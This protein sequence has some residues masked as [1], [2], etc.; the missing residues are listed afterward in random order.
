MEVMAH[1]QTE[2]DPLARW[3]AGAGLSTLDV[4]TREA[5][6]VIGVVDRDLTLR[7]INWT[8]AGLTREGVTG[9]SILDLFPPDSVE[10]A[11]DAYLNVLRTGSTKRFETIYRDGNNVL[12][13]DVH[14]GPIRFEGAVIG[15]IVITSNVTEQRRAHADRDRFFSLSL[16]MLVVVRPNGQLRRVNPALG[17]TLGYDVADL[18]G[19]PFI[20][21]VHP[22]DG[23]RTLEAYDRILRG[24]P[25]T[26]FENR[27]RR[28]DGEY[29]V[30]SWRA[31]VDPI[32]GDVYGVA[33]D[34]TEHRAT[35]AQLRHAMKMDAVGQL[36]GGIAHDFNNLLT[37][38]LG[39]S[40]LAL[41]R[42]PPDSRV[43]RDIEEIQNAGERA[44]TLT[45]QLLAFSRRQ[46]FTPRPL[47]LNAVVQNIEGLL[48][49]LIAEDVE[50][51]TL[52]APNLH[53]VR[54]DQGQVEQILMNLAVNARDAMPRG[55]TLTIETKNREL[56]ERYACE[57]VTV[58]A[59]SYVLLEVSD[60]GEGM[61]EET[62]SRMFEPFFTTKEQGKGTG[63]GLSMVYG[64]VQQ[65]GGHIEVQSEL[66]RGSSFQIY[67]PTVAEPADPL[68]K[69]KTDRPIARGTET[70]LLV[71]DEDLVRNFTRELL[72]AL[73]YRV[74]F[75][76]DGF[77]ALRVQAREQGPI[78]LLI[79][80]VLMPHMNGPQLAKRLQQALPDMGILFLSGYTADAAVRQ[81][82]RAE[83]AFLQKP[84]SPDDLAR[85]TREVLDRGRVNG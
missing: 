71:E 11:R 83:A 73:G 42:L 29:R 26:D 56:D 39:Y 53:I 4:V 60:T 18:I 9:G 17:E 40:L 38:I 81:G 75:A 49:R 45:R 78:D 36:A 41:E 50:L 82:L 6:D 67:L 34:I 21:L 48:R 85:K 51:V 31:T 28:K 7:Y 80:D 44:A 59:G 14:L 43:R 2:G 33:R 27:Y 16:D 24:T 69:V 77:E 68:S 61:N 55:G 10:R 65:S 72:T 15:V 19:T 74:L 84:F 20:D 25:V 57:H 46:V 23:A 58:R 5:P 22:D 47:D 30:F 52:C 37:G 64:I 1:R 70:I 66:G 63:L 76:T 54:T 79:A 35:E 32:I 3:L 8:T 62:K 13:W 12:M